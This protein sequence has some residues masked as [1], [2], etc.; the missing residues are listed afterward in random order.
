MKHGFKTGDRV[1]LIRL[2]GTLSDKV[3]AIHDLWGDEQSA[4]NASFMDG[5]H[6]SI[7]HTDLMKLE[8]DKSPVVVPDGGVWFIARGNQM[9][10]GRA[11]TEKQAIAN[12][13]RAASKATGYIVHRVS[14]WTNVDG[15]GNLTYPQGT[16][17]V[18]V[19]RVGM[20]KEKA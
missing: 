1:R 13:H 2:D 19:K 18:E 15:M 8:N 20:K 14:K 10:W 17:L 11:Q 6:E 7:W 3:F 4:R 12:M 9:G 5:H 16:E